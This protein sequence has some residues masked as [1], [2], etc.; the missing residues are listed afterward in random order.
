MLN[1]TKSQFDWSE[2]LDVDPSFRIVKIV[3]RLVRELAKMVIS[4]QSHEFVLQQVRPNGDK[5]YTRFVLR[6]FVFCTFLPNWIS[7]HFPVRCVRIPYTNGHLDILVKGLAV[8]FRVEEFG[9]AEFVSQEAAER[10]YK[11]NVNTPE[12]GD[13][14]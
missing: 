14:N 3:C 6:G 4:R 8:N 12:R 11:L 13:N 5:F 7:R 1:W 2:I 9:E 10:Y